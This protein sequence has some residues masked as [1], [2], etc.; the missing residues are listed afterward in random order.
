[1]FTQDT[2][3]KIK[4]ISTEYN[5]YRFRSRLEARWAVFFDSLGIKWEYEPEGYDLNRYGW[6]LPD[7]YLPEPDYF[8]E[9]KPENV[10]IEK[11]KYSEFSKLVGKPIILLVGPPDLKFH[12]VFGDGWEDKVFV[13]TYKDYHIY[14]RRFYSCPGNED[15]SS[16]GIVTRSDIAAVTAAR[17]A[18][19][20]RGERP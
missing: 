1:M 10:T 2:T 7:F 20:E 6:Y 4:P 13:S 3:S 15:P 19:F 17:S 11:G 5:G 16:E 8:A 9:V 18:R 14:E 12:D